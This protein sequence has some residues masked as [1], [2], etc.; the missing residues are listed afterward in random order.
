MKPNLLLSYANMLTQIR[1]SGRW[2]LSSRLTIDGKPMWTKQRG[3]QAVESFLNKF[4]PSEQK[5]I[6][7]AARIQDREALSQLVDAAS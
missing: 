3:E 6:K 5:M 1:L 4:T 7:L 2:D